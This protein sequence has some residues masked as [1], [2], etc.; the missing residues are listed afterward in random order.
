MLFLSL[1]DGNGLLFYSSFLLTC[2]YDL[3]TFKYNL[4]R[5]KVYKLCHFNDKI[6]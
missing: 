6:A 1:S 3:K 4:R 5:S 2:S